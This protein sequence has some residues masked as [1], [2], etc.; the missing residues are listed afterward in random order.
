MKKYSNK[1]KYLIILFSLTLPSFVQAMYN[2]N[3]PLIPCNPK[4]VN[5]AWQN[6]C[7][8]NALVR[9]V[10]NLIDFALYLAAP[11]ATAMFAYAGFLYL[12]AQGDPGKIKTAHK[13]FKNVAFGLF[14]VVGAWL[15]VKAVLL[16]L[17]AES[18]GL[19]NLQ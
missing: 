13:I 16:G 7:D 12:S 14:F 18:S 15:I 4:W 1:I 2:P 11:I 5:N 3:D 6:K 19:L 17:G 10:G 8:F 9:G